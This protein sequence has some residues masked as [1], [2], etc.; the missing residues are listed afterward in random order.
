[1]GFRLGEKTKK[2]LRI[3]AK[4]GAIAGAVAL[5]TKGASGHKELSQ[6]RQAEAYVKGKSQL[7]D[8]AQTGMAQ[9]QI[10]QQATRPAPASQSLPRETK[11]VS[12][13]PA[14]AKQVAVGSLAV[15]RAPTPKAKAVAGL[16]GVQAV[17][18]VKPSV[19][20]NVEIKRKLEQAEIRAKASKTP[21]VRLGGISTPAKGQPKKQ[22]RRG[23]TESLAGKMRGRRYGG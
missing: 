2:G 12:N 14:I 17:R 4:I 5:G 21:A 1:M 7:Q 11:A 9:R 6:E 23:F 3:G 22:P 18:S 10:T 16:K 13:R 8:V 20:A 15:A 19:P